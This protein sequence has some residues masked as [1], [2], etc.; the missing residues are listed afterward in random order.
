MK[1]PFYM[2]L[3]EWR[4]AN[5]LT[6]E[7]LARKCGWHPSLVGQYEGGTRLPGLVNLKELCEATGTSADYFLGFVP[8]MVPLKKPAAPLVSPSPGRARRTTLSPPNPQED[9]I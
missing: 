1:P 6:Q 8:A 4:R 2:R 5:G 3:K 7:E 9:G